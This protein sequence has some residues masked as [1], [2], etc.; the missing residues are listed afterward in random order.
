MT[1]VL[2]KD[3]TRQKMQKINIFADQFL[4]PDAISSSKESFF[5]HAFCVFTSSNSL[6]LAQQRC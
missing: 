6:I 5:G 4:L 2:R 3:V 1:E